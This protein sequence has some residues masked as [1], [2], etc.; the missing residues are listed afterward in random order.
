MQQETSALYR[1]MYH[2]TVQTARQAETAFNVERGFP[3]RPFVASEC[4]DE[5]RDGL[6]CGER[7]QLI[8]RQME[9]AYNDENV[10][11]H[12][13]TKHF[14]LKTHFPWAFLQLR[15]TG[16]CEIDIPEWMFDVDYPGHYLR[17]V[18]NVSLTIPCVAGPYTG[19]H[20]RLTLLQS[21]IRTDTRLSSL[22]NRCCEHDRSDPIGYPQGV[23]DSRFVTLCGAKEAIATSTGQNDSGLF[24]VN[25]RDERYLP[26]EYSGAI[27]RWRIELPQENNVFDFDSL[28]D[29]VMRLSYTSREGGEP[30]R[31]AATAAAGGRIPG[32][33]TR[34]IE[35]QREM[36]ETIRRRRSSGDDGQVA[37]EVDLVVEPRM[38]PFVPSKRCIRTTGVT[39]LFSANPCEGN[40]RDVR[41]E[42]IAADKTIN[43]SKPLTVR[44]IADESLANVFVGRIKLESILRGKST[45]GKLVLPCECEKVNLLYRLELA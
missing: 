41:F 23:N 3:N 24:E 44:C 43:C 20:C 45:L 13:L 42:A 32:H 31:R 39:V 33:D 25:F 37:T 4:W 11:E 10:R 40:Y 30:L 15:I 26:F 6:L 2:L 5:F 14:S 17:R 28:T 34:L 19:V 36:P 12:E 22:S 35:V 1:Q 29:V 18:K 38:F 27:G 7:L 8:A 9:K 16:F 21:T